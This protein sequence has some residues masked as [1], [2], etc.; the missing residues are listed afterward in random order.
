MGLI[1]M[2]RLIESI[3]SIS[4]KDEK[5]V[6]HSHLNDSCATSMAAQSHFSGHLNMIK[7]NEEIEL[8]MSVSMKEVPKEERDNIWKPRFFKMYLEG[9]SK[10]IEKEIQA[11]RHSQLSNN[12]D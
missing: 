8:S 12:E 3:L 11:I 7:V 6:D 9:L 5:D 4:I 10:D 1:T 2:E